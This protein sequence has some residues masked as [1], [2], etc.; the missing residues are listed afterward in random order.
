MIFPIS[1]KSPSTGRDAVDNW[2]NF[3]YDVLNFLKVLDYEINKP[4]G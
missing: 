2:K 3:Q 4:K 1:F